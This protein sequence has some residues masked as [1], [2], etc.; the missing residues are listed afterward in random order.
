MQYS[1]NAPK[2]YAYDIG[3]DITFLDFLLSNI[4]LIFL[5]I[6][7]I[8]INPCVVGEDV[9]HLTG[10]YF[11][12][13]VPAVNPW[14]NDRSHKRWCVCYT[15]RKRTAKGYPFK[16]VYVCKFCPSQHGLHLDECL[17]VYHTC[18]DFANV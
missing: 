17:Q 3:S 8:L 9:E 18:L 4:K 6:S 7:N 11:P 10:R 13:L 16:T 14:T 5:L 15:C 2:V 12:S 1:L